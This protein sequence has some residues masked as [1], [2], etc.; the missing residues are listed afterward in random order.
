MGYMRRARKGA[1][2]G[3]IKTR[4]EKATNLRI[5][6]ISTEVVSN[7]SLVFGSPVRSGLLPSSG[8]DRDRNRSTEFGNPR[9]TGPNRRRP[10]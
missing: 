3:C 2:S 7:H 9:K 4:W 8:M 10:V 5:E 1:R 6:A